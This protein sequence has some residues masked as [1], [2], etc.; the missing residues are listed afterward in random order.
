MANLILHPQTLNL[1]SRYIKNP[2]HAVML[3]APTGSGKLSVARHMAANV[4][5]KS[6]DELDKYPYF[7]AIAPIDGKAIPIETIRELQHFT[8]LR[9]PGS[10]DISR[11]IIIESAH[12]MTTEGQNALL[13][14]LEEPPLD[15][16]FI[17]TAPSPDAVLPTIQS[18]VRTIQVTAPDPDELRQN[19]LTDFS[20]S[21]IDK[22][23]MVSGGLPGLMHALLNAADDHPLY[24]A[25]QQA[26]AILQSSAYERLVLVDGLSKQKQLCVDIVFILGQMSRMAL[27]RSTGTAAKRWQ[28]IM[29]AAFKAGQSL[30]SNT[31]AKL[32][33]MNLMLEM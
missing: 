28:H 8:T 33:L 5:G 26:R 13:K 4:L 10:K 23:L 7:T 29:K 27:S 14:T 12:L 11:V 3:A 31:Q 32:I 30:E 16:A 20:A 2:A 24:A 1:V 17:L 9:I 6:T 15:T 19:L 18:R 22:A 25:T 21:E